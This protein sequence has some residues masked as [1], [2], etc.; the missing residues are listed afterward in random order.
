MFNFRLISVLL[1]FFLS[2]MGASA[3]HGP[4]AQP[5]PGV[6]VFP[7]SELREG[8]RGT[9][10]SVFR[11]AT[12]EEF[13][14]EIL[15]VIPNWIGPKQDM[16]IGKLSGANAERT[17]V[18]AGMSGSPVYIDGRLVGAIS[19]SFPFAKEPICGITPFEQMVSA[20][21]R[22]VPADLASA[23]P[24]TFTYSALTSTAWRPAWRLLSGGVASGF[25]SDSRLMAVAGQTFRAIATPVTFSGISQKTLDLFAADFE[26]A[27]IL[28][29]AAS[30][31]ETSITPMKQPTKTTLLGGNSVVV[32]LSRGD[33]QISAA[34][35][36]THR[37]GDKIY[38]F[39]H[40][41]FG[42]GVTSLPMSESHVVTVVPNANNSFKLTVPDSL[43]GSMTQD[44]ST[45]IYGMLGQQP[46]ML[47][48][49]LRIKTTRG[50]E[51]EI[52]FESAIDDILTPLIINAGVTN[53]I[54]A[55]ERGLGDMTIDLDGEIFVRGQQP[56]KVARRFVGPQATMI[57][58]GAATVPLA[59]FMRANFR[60]SD[61]SGITL[62]MKMTDG[63][64]TATLDRIAV[65]RTQVRA[66]E[67][68][69]VTAFLR[70]PSGLVVP[71]IFSVSVP[72]DAAPGALALLVADG[73]A[74]QVASSVTQFTPRSAAEMISTLNRLKR[75]DRLYAILTRTSPGIVIGA[76]EMPNLPPSVLA[77]MNNDRTAGGAK[78][79]VQTVVAESDLPAS[80]YIVTGSQT[81][82]LEVI[83]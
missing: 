38:A 24:R 6:K 11:G 13:G 34:G 3:Q 29:V 33:V 80:E 31:G 55:N 56:I 25:S 51:E 57:A 59:A 37:D 8:M 62:N 5:E 36:V 42:L 26:A 44:R 78:S 10:K 22:T 12:P 58:A 40:P 32:H 28:P 69:N 70:T 47:P 79:V 16:I 61:I 39:G 43:V 60:D 46:R 2:A 30:G 54:S 7:V 77:T 48:V 27:G 63:S 41:F 50:R 82:N 17:F 15:G 21:E 68:V 14:V 76:N 83:R 19:Y 4:K 23:E 49:K 71:Q 35:T 9:A 20:V 53:A 81:L 64:R 45:G 75:S 52:N 1:V 66:G 65:D 18:F 74:A 73:T 67:T 72:K